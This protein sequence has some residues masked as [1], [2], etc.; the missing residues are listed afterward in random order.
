MNAGRLTREEA[1]AAAAQAVAVG[2]EFMATAP[3][4]EAVEAAWTPTGP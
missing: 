3:I 2:R 1:I 4:E